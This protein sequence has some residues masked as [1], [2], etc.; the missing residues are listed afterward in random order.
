M[1]F[2]YGLCNQLRNGSS[3]ITPLTKEEK[4]ENHFMKGKGA[5][6]SYIQLLQFVLLLLKP[7][8]KNYEAGNQ[9]IECI[10]RSVE[11]GNDLDVLMTKVLQCE[12]ADMTHWAKE[13]QAYGGNGILALDVLM[14]WQRMEAGDEGLEAVINFFSFLDMKQEIIKE[15][16][17]AVKLITE[18]D[19]GGVLRRCWQI[20]TLNVIK[21]YFSDWNPDEQMQ[22]DA[23][24]SLFIHDQVTDAYPL[25]KKLATRGNR[26]AL[27]FMGEYYRFGWAGLPINKKLGFHYH[28]LGAEKGE[29]LC[30]LNLAY[31]EGANKEQIL[32]EIIPKILQLAQA[33]DIIAEDELGD[34]F[35]GNIFSLAAKYGGVVQVDEKAEFWR[36]KSAENSYW[37]AAMGLAVAYRDGSRVNQDAGKAI[38]YYEKVYELH[39]EHAGEAA[40]RIGNIYS[41]QKNYVKKVEWWKKSAEEGYDWGMSNLG[42]CYRDG[43]GVQEDQ[44]QAMAWYQKA[45]ELHGDAAGEAV[46]GIGLIYSGQKNYVKKVEWYK[47]SAEEGYDW[48]MRNLGMCYRDGEGV[49][50]DQ[51]QAMAWYQKAYELHGDAAGE[52]VIG[53]GLIYSGQKNYVKKVEWYKKSAEEGYDWGM[54]N[55]GMCYRDG[56]GVQEDQEQAMAWYQKAYELHGDAAGEAVIGI[57]LIYSGQKNYVK[58]VEWYKKSAEEGYDWG[59]HNLGKCYR[60]GEGVQEDQEQ[61]REWYQKAV[62]CHG[63]AEEDAR[64][65]LNDLT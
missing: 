48:G 2:L 39:R 12:E 21:G 59:M 57:G 10:H 17:E 64:K 46:I 6:T 37:R 56:E 22:L 9:F 13:V 50:E 33:G 19:E 55:L 7:Y 28:R 62:D 53:I 1:G 23:A 26:R 3:A 27:Y 25:F 52:A 45:Y 63:D 58:K 24:V 47:K 43:E 18:K 15:A 32:Q 14:L 35:C 44:E 31:E 5:H 51:E 40:N 54:R 30:Q 16:A 41:G 29:P 36:K 61:A 34:A 11:E 8:A 60:D 20:L 65:C 4:I 38:A 42:M 49:Q